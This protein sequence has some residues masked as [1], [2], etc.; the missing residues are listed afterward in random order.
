MSLTFPRKF[1][2]G[3]KVHNVDVYGELYLWPDGHFKY[4]VEM[5]NGDP[6]SGGRINVSFALLDEQQNPLGTYGLPPDQGWA[7]GPCGDR[8]SGR[9]H[10]ELFGN[11]PE[12]K[13]KKAAAVALL[14]R[15]KGQAPDAARLQDL[16]TTGS[17]LVLCPI[18][19]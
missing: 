6:L 18:P 8:R 19:Y 1:T 13:L 5:R 7:V 11:V 2:H 15:P 12:D 10:D 4:A 9:C 16:A 3:Q 14:F 17:E